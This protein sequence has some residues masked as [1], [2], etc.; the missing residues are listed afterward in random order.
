[1]LFDSC[2]SVLHGRQPPPRFYPTH[3]RTRL[4]SLL[5]LPLLLPPP[6]FTFPAELGI[7]E[8]PR[9]QNKVG[10][11]CGGGVEKRDGWGG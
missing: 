1:M 7:G 8:M 10:R 11:G 2:F 6:F 9:K 5:H 3:T 4:V